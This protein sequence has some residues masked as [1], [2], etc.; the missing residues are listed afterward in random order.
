MRNLILMTI[1]LIVVLMLVLGVL[2]PESSDLINMYLQSN[3]W[4]WTVDTLHTITNGLQV[5]IGFYV[6][7]I[8]SAKFLQSRK[9]R[10]RASKKNFFA[11]MRN[12]NKRYIDDF[13]VP[14]FMHRPAFGG[15][16][17]ACDYSEDDWRW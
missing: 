12:D 5:V 13:N 4:W 8:W 3:L 10:G 7:Y 11:E 6:F 16:T 15:T 2:A 1:A 14:P 17:E 9:K